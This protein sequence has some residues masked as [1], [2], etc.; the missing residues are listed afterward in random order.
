MLQK[1][2][3]HIIL[4][5]QLLSI[6]F[7]L[8]SM[9]QV[10]SGSKM[11]FNYKNINFVSIES[12]T[13][14]QCQDFSTFD[15]TLE[16]MQDLKLTIASVFLGSLVVSPFQKDNWGSENWDI[17]TIYI[18][19][20]QI[21]TSWNNSIKFI[22][23]HEIGHL[24]LD[25]YLSDKR[26][27]LKNYKAIKDR[28]WLYIKNLVP[29]LEL[30]KSDPSCSNPN[31]ACSKK[32][33][34]LIADSPVD[35]NGPSPSVLRDK[36]YLDNK[37]ELDTFSNIVIPYH[38]LFADLVQ[39]LVFDDPNINEKAFLGFG[40]PSEPCRTF[41]ERLPVNFQS[42]EPHCRLSSV[43]VDIWNKFVKPML[44][45]KK[46]ILLKLAGAI[47]AEIEPQLNDPKST[48]SS[49]VAG[50]QL[51]NQLLKNN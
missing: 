6:S 1:K 43:R 34:K 18:T 38:E 20:S 44:P 28:N 17:G 10:N 45:N 14:A 23:P 21:D 51:L 12:N 8:F 25:N 3:V 27:V 26:L 5:F 46:A 29:I 31:S 33:A 16:G 19:S 39:A 49:T 7:P 4:L 13:G 15:E 30:R 36:Y 41:N 47:W 2:V 50:K 40:M 32:I 35:L 9:A 48:P 42:D 24:I 11:C 37:V 22:F